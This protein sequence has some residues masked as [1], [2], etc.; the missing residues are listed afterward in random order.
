MGT[1]AQR[2]VAYDLGRDGVV[3]RC[4]LEIPTQLAPSWEAFETLLGG[5]RFGSSKLDAMGAEATP[6]SQAERYLRRILE[7][8][9]DAV[10][11]T[12]I[13]GRVTFANP[14]AQQL[15]GIAGE[16][17]LGRNIGELL[18]MFDEE[19]HADIGAI[20]AVVARDG[21]WN[22]ELLQRSLDGRD[23]L[24]EVAVSSL[25]DD[26]STVLGSVSIVR[27]ISGRRAIERQ[28]AHQATHDGLTGLLNRTA[29]L[30]ELDDSLALESVHPLWSSWISTDSKPSTT[31]TATTGETRSFG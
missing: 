26:D 19:G 4:A 25:R 27:E 20:A 11:A 15:Y 17:A 5:L 14:A 9:S 22:G 1:G 24:V 10:I 7:H 16:D 3:R 8:V 18:A 6:Y 29:F 2:D 21:H 31:F 30:K 13:D 12:D 23:L 28:I